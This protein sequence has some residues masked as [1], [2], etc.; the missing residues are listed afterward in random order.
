MGGSIVLIGFMGAGKS[1]VG[2]LLA[3]RL[4]FSFVDTDRLVQDRAGR[5]IAEIWRTQGEDAFRDRE[6]EV[7][8]EVAVKEGHVIATGG[9]A[10]CAPRNAELLRRAG[11]VIHLDVSLEAVRARTSRGRHRPLLEGKDDADLETLLA[12]RRV[13][14]EAIADVTL[15]ASA[16]DA[17]AL[18]DEILE[19]IA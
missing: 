18:V 15:D 6:H 19:A 3:E 9:G 1:T 13:A 5:S 4:G 12:E 11:A 2:R 14:Y 7:I 10:P 17:P 16:G 8:A